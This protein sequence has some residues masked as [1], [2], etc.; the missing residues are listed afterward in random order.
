MEAVR[1]LC[2]RGIWL[3][4]GRVHSDGKAD[5][6]VEE[7]FD[8]ASNGPSFSCAN[9]EYGL[10]IQK[11]ALRNCHGEEVSCFRPGDD[12]AVE[13]LYD[14]QKRIERPIIALGILGI[15]GACFTSNMLL[16]GNRPDFLE[17][18]GRI[19]CT[20]TSIPL[21]PQNY[22][23]KMIVR[24][25]N[26]KD[27]IVTYQEVAAFSIAGDLADYGYT[28]EYLAYARHSTPVVVP[29]VWQLPDGTTV[30]VSLNKRTVDRAGTL[31]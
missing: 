30:P 3:K 17:G 25:S 31:V 18:T 29:Y 22:A 27:V 21:L 12:L 19:M 5:E 16:D 1:S 24:A 13:I 14:A 23:V 2:Q 4:D 20:F 6:V 8:S 26:V 11:V 15:N 7:Y 28:G 9:A 10:V